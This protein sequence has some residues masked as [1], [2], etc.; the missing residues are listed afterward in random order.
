RR[1]AHRLELER[2]AA[3]SL[4]PRGT[5][6]RRRRRHPGP[7][8]DPALRANGLR[9]DAA[10][11]RTGRDLGAGPRRDGARGRGARRGPA[12]LAGRDARER[13]LMTLLTPLGALVAAA[14]VLPLAATFAATRR[15]HTVRA[16]LHLRVPR[17]GT[18]LVALAALVGV[19]ILIG[20][21]AT[22]PALSHDTKQ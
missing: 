15:A 10:R 3:H 16:A 21:A 20:L 5:D 19:F 11:R 6:A 7:A 22:Q 9:P 14:V 4:E 8:R 2:V 18:D 12:L 1:R 13:L 17:R